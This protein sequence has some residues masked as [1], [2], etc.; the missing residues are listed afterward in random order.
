MI[1][2]ST[3]LPRAREVKK[4]TRHRN[5][6][7]SLTDNTVCKLLILFKRSWMS[8]NSDISSGRRNYDWF[9]SGT[10]AQL[11]CQPASVNIC[12]VHIPRCLLFAGKTLITWMRGLKYTQVGRKCRCICVDSE[13]TWIRHQRVGCCVRT[14]TASFLPVSSCTS[15]MEIITLL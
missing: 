5:C 1:H 7:S 12:K 8:H 2:S 9:R 13:N 6:C 11:R 4:E 3:G 14:N 10:S 15:K